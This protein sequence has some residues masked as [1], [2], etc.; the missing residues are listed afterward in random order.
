MKSCF[1]F[2]MVAL[3]AA[4]GSVKFGKDGASAESEHSEESYQY[5]YNING[6]DTG[7]RTFSSKADLCAG[8]LNDQLNNHC[9][10]SA[11]TKQYETECK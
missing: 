3:I 1:S 6:C 2:L 4:C 10:K 8:L 5:S 11:R 9:A 7:V